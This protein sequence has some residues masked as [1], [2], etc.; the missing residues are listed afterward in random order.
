M[1][2][3][4]HPENPMHRA[5]LPQTVAAAKKLNSSLQILEAQ[6]PNE[7]DSAFA[8]ATREHADAMQVYGDLIFSAHRTRIVALAAKS[9]LPVL[10]LY[11]ADVVAGGL[12]FYGPSS[13]MCSG[14]PPRTWIRS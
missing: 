5:Y 9:R 8:A 14:A 13:P 4:I 11:K 2:L 3:L 1:A 7:L 10:Y 6:T 12:M